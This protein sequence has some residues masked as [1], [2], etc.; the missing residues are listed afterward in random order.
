MRCTAVYK[1]AWCESVFEEPEEVP[2]GWFAGNRMVH[3][4]CPDCGEDEFYEVEDDP[5]EE[6]EDEELEVYDEEI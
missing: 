3:L 1:C 6:Y 2:D 4:V 5:R